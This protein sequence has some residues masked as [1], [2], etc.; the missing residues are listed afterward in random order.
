MARNP[1]V[2]LPK[3]I[4]HSFSA[5]NRGWY[6]L[7]GGR[8]GGKF[9]GAPL[10][11]LTTTGRKTGKSRTCPLL[12]VKDGDSFVLTASHGGHDDH[13][14]WYLNLLAN[15]DVIVQDGDRKVRGRARV[16]T[17][18]ERGQLYQRFVEVMATYGEYAKATDREIPV[19][20]VE[21]V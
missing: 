2:R 8:V 4:I 17:D 11:L 6:K 13:P 1:L 7:T 21:P 14:G 20:V 18:P 15:P 5:I 3:P 16:T 9:R 12:A 19:V 10:V